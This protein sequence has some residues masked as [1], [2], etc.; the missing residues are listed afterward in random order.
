M[1]QCNI[2]TPELYFIHWNSRS[3]HTRDLPL[4]DYNIKFKIIIIIFILH[5]L[6][7]HYSYQINSK[8][9]NYDVLCSIYGVK[10]YT[11][12]TNLTI[13]IFLYFIRWNDNSIVNSLKFFLVRYTEGIVK[14]FVLSIRDGIIIEIDKWPLF[15]FNNLVSYQYWLEI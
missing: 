6:P 11:I 9:L 1:R 15:V 10:I 8:R 14:R 3:L 13:H 4:N 5:S 2:F 12:C 7:L